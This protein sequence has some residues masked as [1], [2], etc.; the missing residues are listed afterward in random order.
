M[1]EKPKFEDIPYNIMEIKNE[2]SEIKDMIKNL[3]TNVIKPNILCVQG[4]AEYLG[5]STS[6]IYTKV[7][8]REIPF[9]KRGKKL[10]FLEEELENF[11]R[12]G[13]ALGIEE[14]EEQAANFLESKSQFK[15]I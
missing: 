10:Y 8:K 11:I 9:R 2:M 14:I 13:K 6:T 3:N 5:L 12:D 4:A 1:T 7:S 15:N